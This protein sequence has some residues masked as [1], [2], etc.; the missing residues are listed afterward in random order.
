MVV[1]AKQ[2]SP[3]AIS[4]LRVISSCAQYTRLATN[5]ACRRERWRHHKERLNLLAVEIAKEGQGEKHIL[6]IQA[7]IIH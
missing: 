4:D 2:V 1:T 5:W 7:V 6:T 3:L